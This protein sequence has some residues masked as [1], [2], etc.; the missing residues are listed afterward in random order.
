MRRYRR[1][2][3]PWV[4]AFKD[5]RPLI[6]PGAFVDPSARVI[7]SVTI[8]D[9]ASVWPMAVLRADSNEIRIGARAAILDLA[10]VEAPEGHG[11]TVE[12][13]AIISHG[14]IVHGALIQCG[15]IV[16]IGAIVLDG[17]VISPGAIVGAGALVP[18]GSRIPAESLVMGVPGKVIRL[19]TEE[20]RQ[21][22]LKQVEE[23]Y[24]KSRLYMETS[25]R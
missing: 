1:G 3:G 8:E 17:A 21:R 5:R 9:G 11:V 16:G 24:N 15:A 20:E 13:E 6:H 22:T 19:T 12:E 18:P 23:L 2:Q 14:A 25:G 10:L 4:S 7:G